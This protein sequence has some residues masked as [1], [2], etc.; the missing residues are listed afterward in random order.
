[1][2]SFCNH[3]LQVGLAHICWCLLRQE[4]GGG[5]QQRCPWVLQGTEGNVGL[6]WMRVWRNASHKPGRV[7]LKA[8]TPQCC[9]QATSGIP[10]SHGVGLDFLAATT[11]AH[12][13]AQA[14]EV[15]SWTCQLYK[16][17][18]AWG[19]PWCHAWQGHTHHRGPTLFWDGWQWGKVLRFP[20]HIASAQVQWGFQGHTLHCFLG[21]NSWAWLLGRMSGK[22]EQF[23]ESPFDS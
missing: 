6:P 12:F 16:K 19:R 21:F 3:W 9:L 20:V 7:R 15:N 11:K 10:L 13:H 17:Q 22:N 1:M 5:G 8:H 18:A 23:L 4:R 14:V 2:V